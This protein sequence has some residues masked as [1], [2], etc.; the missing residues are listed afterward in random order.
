MDGRAPSAVHTAVF[1]LLHP[2]FIIYLI[3]PSGTVIF[4]QQFKRD[5]QQQAPAII[6][7]F[8]YLFWSF[9]NNFSKVYVN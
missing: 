7:L 8:I 5:L 6:Y 2:L 1:K 4:T 3:T 9:T